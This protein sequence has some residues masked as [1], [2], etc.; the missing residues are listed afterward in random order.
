MIDITHKRP[1][2]RTAVALA[3]VHCN[4]TALEAVRSR[5]VPK[6]DVPATSRAA[7][8]LA[9]KRTP[10][11]L[12][13]CHPIP[14]EYADVHVDVA[15]D[16]IVFEV[17]VQAIART[18]VEVEALT[19][20]GVAALNACD[21]LKSIDP[22]LWIGEIRLQRKTGGKHSFRDRF[23]RPLTAAVLVASDSVSA[24]KKQDAAGVAIR[25]R[26]QAEGLEVRAYKIVPDDAEKIA[27]WVRVWS[28]E[29]RFD[30]VF[31]CGGTGLGPRDCSVEAVRPLLEREIPG[32]AEAV[33]IHGLER[34]P[35][36]AL[37]RGVAGQ[38]GT[39]LIVT[40][41]GS[42]RGA[43]ESLDALMPWV[44]HVIRT[45]DIAYRHDDPAS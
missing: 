27:E 41:P 40:L 18:G 42:T 32:I 44:L 14:I 17:E 37:S 36:A 24:G 2:L 33:R 13:F 30:L 12:P 7:A 9:V 8:L 19:A 5:T 39:T 21:M 26:L 11:L 35:Y 1:S 20:A 16:C 29:D 6:G 38:R 4:A 25:N 3:T 10:D 45:F 43:E 28:D 23:E 22:N 34:T 15:G 31:T